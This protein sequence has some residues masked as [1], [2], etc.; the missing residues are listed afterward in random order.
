MWLQF[1]VGPGP[2]G[3][4]FGR[5]GAS[6]G[7]FGAQTG[8]RSTPNDPDRTSDSFKMQPHELFETRVP[9]TFRPERLP[10]AARCVPRSI[11]PSRPVAAVMQA[12][13]AKKYTSGGRHPIGSRTRAKGY[14]GPSGWNKTTV[15]SASSHADDRARHMAWIE[16]ENACRIALFVSR[17]GSVCFCKTRVTY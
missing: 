4:V 9:I 16:E 11:R 5:L 7:P 14:K 3:V 1:E 10:A 8:H 6:L 12:P 17:F 2:V 15:K 13:V